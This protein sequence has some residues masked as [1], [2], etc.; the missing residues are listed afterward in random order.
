MDD[1]SLYENKNQ[2]QEHTAGIQHQFF[3][4]N[5]QWK[6]VK[7]TSPQLQDYNP[8][9]PHLPIQT[10]QNVVNWQIISQAYSQYMSWQ[11]TAQ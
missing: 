2:R 3:S 10:V 4:F 1:T 11:M 8:H 6:A 5:K 7:G 9:P